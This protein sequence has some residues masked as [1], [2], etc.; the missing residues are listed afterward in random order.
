MKHL[1]G[2]FF[3]KLEELVTAGQWSSSAWCDNVTVDTALGQHVVHVTVPSESTAAALSF[4]AA[5]SD[6]SVIFVWLPPAASV[7]TAADEFVFW[8]GSAVVGQA[9]NGGAVATVLVLAR[10]PIVEWLSS[11]RVFSDIVGTWTRDGSV[12]VVGVVDTG[13]IGVEVDSL[14]SGLA[15][16]TWTVVLNGLDV[17]PQVIGTLFSGPTERPDSMPGF[18]PVVSVLSESH[19]E[20]SIA[21]ADS[22]GAVEFDSFTVVVW[23]PTVVTNDTS[24]GVV[25]LVIVIPKE[26][27]RIPSY[28]RVA[29]TEIVLGT[30]VTVPQLLASFINDIYW[31]TSAGNETVSTLWQA[32]ASVETV[33]R[34]SLVFWLQE[35]NEF[36]QISE[37]FHGGQGLFGQ[38]GH[39]TTSSEFFSVDGA[40]QTVHIG[41]NLLHHK[42]VFD[43]GEKL[44]HGVFFGDNGGTLFEEFIDV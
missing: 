21:L 36:L 25:V 19:S 18:G 3:I 31:W 10:F 14:D 20:T 43:S 13:G 12:V 16:G 23:P 22:P 2:D 35:R 41:D 15:R 33:S 28:V 37:S 4:T 30:G 5:R 38:V 7:G 27:V 32:P 11:V 8:T 24:L 26:S 40:F 17:V 1:N 34:D 42:I 39:V 6:S 44:V 9:T 29:T